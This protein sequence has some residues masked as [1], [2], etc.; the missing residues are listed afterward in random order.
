MNYEEKLAKIR[1]LSEDRLRKEILIPL[2][3]GMRK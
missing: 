2:F 1:L 3:I